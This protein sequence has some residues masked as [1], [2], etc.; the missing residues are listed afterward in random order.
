MFVET[1]ARIDC[2][3]FDSKCSLRACAADACSDASA[4]LQCW[5]WRATNSR[6]AA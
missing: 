5:W 1:D 3:H 6:P 2:M 4:M